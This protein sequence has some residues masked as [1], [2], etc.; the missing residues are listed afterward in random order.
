MSLQGTVKFFSQKGFGFI[1]PS[2]GTDDVF[3]HYT[4]IN[5][6]GYKTLN[7]GESVTF[8]KTFDDAKQKWSASNVTGAGDGVVRPRHNHQGGR[9]GAYAYG[10]GRGGAVYQGGSPYNA[11][12]GHPAYGGP[13]AYQG[14]SAY[15]AGGGHPGYGG[16][17]HPQGSYPGGGAP[18]YQQG[19][20]A[21]QQ[22]QQQQ[23]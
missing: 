22:Q 16:G 14:G 11:G 7:D 15:N 23:W 4:H 17:G 1:T 12:G 3:V 8:D 13:G 19:G 2:D 5:K 21:P 6:E 9:G 10:G 18:D 20:G